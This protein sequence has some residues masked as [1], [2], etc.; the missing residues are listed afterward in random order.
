MCAFSG[1]LRGEHRFKPFLNQIATACNPPQADDELASRLSEQSQLLERSIR[2]MDARAQELHGCAERVCAFFAALS[3][4]LEAH[5]E[6]KAAI[7][8]A[9][10]QRVRA[11]KTQNKRFPAQCL[12]NYESVSTLA[13]MQA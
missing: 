9:G 1:N 7:D 2:S 12:F 4:E 10:E 8:E 6:N 5:E 13:E 3:A 11:R